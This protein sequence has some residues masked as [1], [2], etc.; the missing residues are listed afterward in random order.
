M[1]E[2]ISEMILPGTYIEVRAEGLI[3]VGAIATGNIG[4]VGTAARGP[5][6]T[7]QA[8][9]SYTEAIDTFG[10]YDSWTSPNTADHPLTLV[11]TLEQAFR[12]GGKNVFAVRIANGD[13]VKADADVASVDD[14]G[15]AI[16]AKDPGSYG[17]SIAYSVV[18]EGTVADPVF[19]LKLTYKQTT[20]T[21]TGET[22]GEIQAQV[23]AA[24]TLVDAGDPVDPAKAM[25]IVDPA[26]NLTGGEDHPDV[27]ASDLADGLTVLEDEPVNILIVGGFGSDV[28]RGAVG[29]HVEATENEGKERIAI[30]GAGADDSATV[31]AEADAL[32]DK[33]IV[34]VAPGLK[35]VD[36][37]ADAAVDLPP[38]YTAALVAG[39]LS[40]LA[41][42]VSLTNKTLPVDD[43]SAHY[44]STV[45]KK[46]LQKR[47]LLVRRKFGFQVVKGITT[48]TGAFKQISI[49]RIV[50][51]AKA[52]V[53]SGSDPYIG[54]L[55]NARVRAA[56]K[57][58]LDGFLSQMVL[59]EML[60]EY[61]LEVSA[62]RRQ[63][64]AGIAAVTM[65]LKPT[66]SIDF[67]RVTMNLQ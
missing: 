36:A 29:A 24:S 3:S 20:E 27:S 62:T 59:D 65:T 15:F 57:A 12:G 37:A 26:A 5:R 49:R 51:Y 40:T 56:L 21:Y 60:V 52:G 43:L 41:P 67:I 39:K 30:L 8:L 6:N 63:E 10:D 50:D 23:A 16:T 7:V 31:E 46:L 13:P 61:Q 55:N 22:I 58:T 42:Q 33:R 64:I 32:A 45:Y 34:L 66:F 44:S 4:V 38:P 11:R 2:S 53:R 54:R 28:A 35:T 47:V 1:S 17:N 48:D 9:G 14:A 19:K 18:N 25:A